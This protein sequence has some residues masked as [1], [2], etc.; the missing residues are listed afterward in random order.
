MNKPAAQK[1]KFDTVFAPDGAAS[2]HAPPAPRQKQHFTRADMEALTA[3]AFQAGKSGAEAAATERLASAT[4]VLS[5]AIDRAAA[6]MDT[7]IAQHREQSVALAFEIGRVAAGAW[8]A[9]TAMLAVESAIKD[10][11]HS[12]HG[13]PRLIVRVQPDI[14]SALADRLESLAQANGFQGRTLLAA[15]PAFGPG[16]CRIE[17]SDGG[18]ERDPMAAIEAAERAVAQAL[19]AKRLKSNGKDDKTP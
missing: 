16:Q 15:E 4:L 3:E 5:A 14:A 17:W 13:E 6:Q 1:F 2:L 12:Q 19:A 18:L 8:A 11:M 9:H 7:V 10:A